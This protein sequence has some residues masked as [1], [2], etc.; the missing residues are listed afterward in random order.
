MGT[1]FA[2]FS[3]SDSSV[4]QTIGL[5]NLIPKRPNVIEMIK[6]MHPEDPD[7]FKKL[8]ESSA[9]ESK[10]LI[11]YLVSG[12]REYYIGQNLNWITVF[13][14]EFGFE[15]I[16]VYTL[17]L[18]KNTDKLFFTIGL[19]DDDV[20][21]FSVIKE[22]KILTH[23]VSGAAEIYG[24]KQSLGDAA[25]FAETFNV[26]PRK[27]Q[28]EQILKTNDLDLYKKL[29]ELENLVSVKLWLNRSAPR[30]LRWKKVI[31]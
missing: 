6:R 19:F 23:H 8:Q 17:R 21:T 24:M 27:E 29:T 3:I 7:M 2:H 28:L 1:K 15:S 11:Q 26:V 20:F 5:L 25:I 9:P 12:T 30:E 14:E 10:K 22:G 13:S 4:D 31:L 16:D 18:S